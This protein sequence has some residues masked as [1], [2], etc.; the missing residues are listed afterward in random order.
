MSDGIPRA[1]NSFTFQIVTTSMMLPP[2]GFDRSR[3]KRIFSVHELATF[4]A[5]MT[6]IVPLIGEWVALILFLLPMVWFMTVNRLLFGGAL[7]P[8]V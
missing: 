6:V 2:V 5:I 8:G 4:A 1:L 3:L 7:E